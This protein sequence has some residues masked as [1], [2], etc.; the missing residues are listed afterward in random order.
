TKLTLFD[1]TVI[2]L[3]VYKSFAESFNAGI[4]SS[5]SI[6]DLLVLSVGV[7]LLFAVMFYLIGFISKK[8][9]FNKEDQIT[10]QFCGT[11]KSLVHG[12]VFSAILFRSEEHTSELQ[13]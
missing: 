2:L 6:L 1:K 10:A 4:F 5:V 7:L 3:I 9:D 13:S 12:T 11:K 8:L